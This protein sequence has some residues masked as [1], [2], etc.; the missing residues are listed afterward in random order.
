MIT[1]FVDWLVNIIESFGYI[2]VALSMFIESFFAPI[3]SEIILPFS[4]FVASN[5]SLNIYV[6]V[7][8]ATIAAYLGTLPFYFVGYLGEKKVYDLLDKYGKYLFISKDNLN[9]GY[10]V[11]EKHGN[12]FVLFGR[13][14]PIIRTVISFPAGAS[15]MNF[16]VFTLYTLLGTAVWSSL[17]ATA[18]YFL[19]EKWDVVSVYI[20]KYEKAVI[21]IILILLALYIVKGI[22]DIRKKEIK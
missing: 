5:G 18:G 22:R 3:P 17:L 6:V 11:F 4:G 7:I 19:G 13:V 1:S 15:K 21:V 8:V 10:G 16:G 2:G 14:V 12:I 9:K 20:S